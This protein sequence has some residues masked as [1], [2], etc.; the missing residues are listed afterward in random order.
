MSKI[1]FI[2]IIALTGVGWASSPKTVRHD[3][4][5]DFERGKLDKV[6]VSH[7]GS[8]TPAPVMKQLIDTGE[9]F[10]W[11]MA[12]GPDGALY[13]ATG[14]DGFMYEIS[15]SG[16]SALFYDAPEMNVFAV[17]VDAKNNVYAATSPDGQVYK[18]NHIGERSEFFNPDASYIWDLLVDAQG[19]LLVATGEPAAIYKVAPNGQSRVLFQGEENHVRTLFL[20]G[21]DLYFG[22]SS[23][24][25]VYKI[26]AQGKPFVL[27]DTQL[28]EVFALAPAQDGYL[29]AAASG[30]ERMMILPTAP[31]SRTETG[32]S[33]GND[34][35]EDNQAL[36]GQRITPTDR[37]STITQ[38]AP[39][40][41]FYIS[42]QG[43]GKDLWVGVDDKIQS[44]LPDDNQNLLVGSG[45]SGKLLTIN[46]LGEL[47]V[48]LKNDE[49]HI[50]ALLR[51]KN[52]HLVLGMSNLGR[53][54]EIDKRKIEKAVFESESI[55][56]GL[57]A[58]WGVLTWE[59]ESADAVRFFTRSGNTEQPS[60]TWSPWEAVKREGDLYRITSPMARFVQWKCEFASARARVDKVEISYQQMNLAPRL[61]SIIVHGPGQFYEV[62]ESNSKR[63]GIAFPAPLPN[64]VEKKGW[65]T[66]DWLFD[67]PNFD[68]LTFD[69]YYRRIGSTFWRDLAKELNVNIFS[70]NSEQ[71]MD[72]EYEI[73]VVASD[74]PA[75]TKETALFGEKVSRL[76]IIDN[77]GPRI[78]KIKQGNNAGGKELTFRIIDDWNLLK[79]VEISIDA[80]GWRTLAPVDGILDSGKEEFRVDIASPT[81]VE[82]A[83][84]ATDAVGNVHVEHKLFD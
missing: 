42:P 4:K 55:D 54:Y 37:L 23:N 83:I 61:S 50:T 7:D 32:Q 33:S 36:T 12:E 22:T 47:S 13:I 49:S 78:E 41:L 45:K 80:E 20:S 44:I 58:H 76:F 71:M 14:I 65:R 77:S 57:P 43:Y 53:V 28:K 74:A 15:A 25:F 46:A 72:G 64:K 21:S 66:V 84:K 30:E 2:I 6:T 48:L 17:A 9:P 52:G 62:K 24:G 73:K 27:F 29:Y 68:A 81:A 63:K 26:S 39:T 1:Y 18:I 79:S 75:N 35:S 19:N 59:G 8:I 5:I 11:D 40:S 16:D 3:S 70:W 38:S 60:K 51:R 56:A 82:A 34:D 67:D 31:T 69:L 10:V